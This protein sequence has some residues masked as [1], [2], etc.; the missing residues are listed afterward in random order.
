MKIQTF[1]PSKA[2][3][4]FGLAINATVFTLIG[5]REDVLDLL[6]SG[7]DTTRVLALDYIDEPFGHVNVILPCQL[8]VFYY[9]YRG[10]GTDKPNRIK[11][12]IYT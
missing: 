3:V 6:L 4:C 11:I 8:S 10:V 7:G 12:K 2:S 1:P 5:E 9:V